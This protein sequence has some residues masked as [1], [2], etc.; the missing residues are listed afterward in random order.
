MYPSNHPGPVLSDAQ[1]S[2]NA[3]QRVED[4]T[5]M[6]CNILPADRFLALISD[7][8]LYRV[9][10]NQHTSHLQSQHLMKVSVASSLL[11]LDTQERIQLRE[12]RHP[13]FAWD[14][15]IAVFHVSND[16]IYYRLGA[17]LYCGSP[18]AANDNDVAH[19]MLDVSQALH[20]NPLS[21]STK[22]PP[23]PIVRSTFTFMRELLEDQPPTYFSA[24]FLLHDDGASV[25]RRDKVLMLML[26]VPA[27]LKSKL[28]QHLVSLIHA[29]YECALHG[30]PLAKLRMNL[31]SMEVPQQFVEFNEETRLMHYF[32]N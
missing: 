31:F 22:L 29:R 27:M 7:P 2:I 21:C 13:R 26:D 10:Y 12:D 4:T 28:A 5:D 14:R 25:Q 9:D 1:A 15:I 17:D 8:M 16:M 19:H 32:Q 3:L 11:R 23:G 18:T 6:L 24:Q 30:G 20:M